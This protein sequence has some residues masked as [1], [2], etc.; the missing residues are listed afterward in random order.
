MSVTV[1]RVV[2]RVTKGDSSSGVGTSTGIGSLASSTAFVIRD[3]D[4]HLSLVSFLV[5]VTVFVTPLFSPL[6]VSVV[7]LPLIVT[8]CFAAAV[9]KRQVI[10]RI[11]FLD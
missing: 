10:S 7:L 6:V 2:R 5:T 1:D 8:C 9:T 4:C 3:S 11:V